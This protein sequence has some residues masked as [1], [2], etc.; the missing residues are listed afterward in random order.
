MLDTLEHDTLKQLGIGLRARQVDKARFVR[1]P[2][3]VDALLSKWALW[4]D[5]QD[6][7]RPVMRSG[8]I[9]AAVGRKAS[10]G[11]AVT[12]PKLSPTL[13]GK[14]SSDVVQLTS[15]SP[16]SSPTVVPADYKAPVSEDIFD[17]DE[18]VP[19]AS[20]QRQTSTEPLT[21]TAS[22]SPIGSGFA[23]K[24][25][26]STTPRT[27]LRAIIAET[28]SANAQPRPSPPAAPASRPAPELK[29][30][31]S[32]GSVSSAASGSPGPAWRMTAAP[33]SPLAGP[34]GA[35]R[36]AAPI[37]RASG[38][39]T[40]SSLGRAAGATALSMA[41]AGTATPPLAAR[42]S[43]AAAVPRA[44]PGSGEVKNRPTSGPTTTSLPTPPRRPS[45]PTLGV[46]RLS[47]VLCCL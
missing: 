41:K 6:I 34:S 17:M 30:R 47:C 2:E 23:W 13:G 9:G 29:S 21:P 5:E 25:P 46:R 20:A 38:S 37:Q 42:Q 28:L 14:R 36:P 8:G 11:A 22:S 1:S 16:L 12:S 45:S 15:I 7:P 4:L 3:A 32:L 40:P 26:L 18:L 19:S 31:P 44:I 10:K 33:P 39:T 24:T 35:T 27:D 43:S